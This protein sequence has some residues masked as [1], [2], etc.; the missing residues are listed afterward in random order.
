MTR[1]SISSPKPAL[2][3]IAAVLSTVCLALA[4]FVVREGD[5]RLMIEIFAVFTFAQ[6]WNFLAGY[7]GLM[8]FGQQLF[9]G[10]GAYFV[11]LV[12]STLHF[13][14]AVS[15]TYREASVATPDSRCIKFRAT[16]SQFNSV[17]ANPL[18]SATASPLWHRSPLA[19]KIA[20]AP[21]PPCS[22]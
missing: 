7:V 14:P 1:H 20:N 4:P 12:S 8:S 18:T 2:V 10:L 15:A 3:A 5:L 21:Q 11:F 22:S 6:S 17:R 9:I 13:V 16:R 19:F